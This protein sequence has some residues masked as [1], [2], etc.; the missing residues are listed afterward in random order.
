MQSKRDRA[1]TAEASRPEPRLAVWVS[2]HR[3]PSETLA[4]LTVSRSQ[5]REARGRGRNGKQQ[6]P[7]PRPPTPSPAPQGKKPARLR[8]SPPP[9][10]AAAPPPVTCSWVDARLH[11]GRLHD[12]EPP[13]ELGH[14]HQVIALRARVRVLSPTTRWFC[15]WPQGVSKGSTNSPSN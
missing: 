14:E 4:T 2:P 11:E 15:V 3:R 12:L 7:A 9:S 6:L 13:E 1:V 10:A 5:S 8:P